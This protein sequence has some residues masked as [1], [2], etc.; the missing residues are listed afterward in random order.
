MLRR[1][2]R[3]ADGRGRGTTST[4]VGKR[5]SIRARE[6]TDER[7]NRAFVELAD[8]YAVRAAEIETASGTQSECNAASTRRKRT[9]MSS[10]SS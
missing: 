3:G 9:G 8:E 10:S 4:R 7:T 5:C 2:H 6:I 1:R